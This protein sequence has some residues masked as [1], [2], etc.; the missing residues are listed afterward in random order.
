MLYG[1]GFVFIDICIQITLLRSIPGHYNVL[2]LNI[3]SKYT[4]ENS[5]QF[6]LS[7]Y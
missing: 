7:K 1:R 4:N 6:H 2:I 5:Q 3:I